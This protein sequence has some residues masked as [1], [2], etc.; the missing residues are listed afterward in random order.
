MK[1]IKVPETLYPKY[2]GCGYAMCATLN[3]VMLDLIY[4]VDIFKDFDEFEG[5][6]Q[7]ALFEAMKAL[8]IKPEVGKKVRYLQSLGDVSF[9]LCSCYEFNEL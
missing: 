4:F 6:E 3:E 7:P 1:V 9:G 2:R 8:I 5:L